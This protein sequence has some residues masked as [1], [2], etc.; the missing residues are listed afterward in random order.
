M[1]VE[2]LKNV[3]HL[4]AVQISA[5]PAE[6]FVVSHKNGITLLGHAI[7]V[8]TNDQLKQASSLSELRTC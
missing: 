1:E 2:R 3:G 8:T 7:V 4:Q 5:F 6:I